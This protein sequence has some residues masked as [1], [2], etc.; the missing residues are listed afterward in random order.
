VIGLA[1]P[2]MSDELCSRP[3]TSDATPAMS[4][5]IRLG[6]CF[7]NPTTNSSTN[8]FVQVLVNSIP[9]CLRGGGRHDSWRSYTPLPVTSTYR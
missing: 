6:N 8:G 1:M 5:A 3:F 7:A 4:S 2:L 9:K